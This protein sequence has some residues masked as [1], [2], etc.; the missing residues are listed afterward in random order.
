M[1]DENRVRPSRERATLGEKACSLTKRDLGS[2]PVVWVKVYKGGW[3]RVLRGRKAWGVVGVN[4]E[5]VQVV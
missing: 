2:L 1:G 3:I 5:K 4:A